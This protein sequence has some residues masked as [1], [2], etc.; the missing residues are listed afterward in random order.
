MPDAADFT[1]STRE[2]A[3]DL[4]LK[5]KQIEGLIAQLPEDLEQAEREQEERMRVLEGKLRETE[6]ASA[7]RWEERERLLEQVD[8]AIG[9]CKRVV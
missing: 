6:T 7:Q 5:Q 4:V 8:T 3:R 1:E 2:L 9:K